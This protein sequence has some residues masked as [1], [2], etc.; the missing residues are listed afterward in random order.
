MPRSTP[1]ARCATEALLLLAAALLALAALAATAEAASPVRLTAAFGDGARLGR[2]T[3]LH[4]GLAVLDPWRP[5]VTEVRLLTPAGIDFSASGLGMATCVRPNREVERVLNPVKHGLC[6]GNALM[7]TGTARAE[8]RLDRDRESRYDG[9]AQIALYSGESVEDKPG[10]IVVADTY[11]PMRAQ[12]TYRGYL[13]IP[14]PRFGIGIALKVPPVPR[15]PFG[16]PIA[17]LSFRLVLG[18]DAVRYVRTVDG[19]VVPF[20]PQA[21]PLPATCPAEGFRFRAIV[22]FAED[23]GVPVGDTRA[24]TDVV[25]PCPPAQ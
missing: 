21:V 4:L 23:E 2:S 16:A 15:P 17:L 5:P 3:S 11:R 25:V 24:Q 6:P 9:G 10:L 14:P 18:G 19:R 7:G 22:R 8:L 13:Y 1:R 12:L 20:Q